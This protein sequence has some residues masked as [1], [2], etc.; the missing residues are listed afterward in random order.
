M[1]SYLSVKDGIYDPSKRFGFK[2]IT[3]E[4][5]TF[6]WG[7]QPIKVKAGQEIELPHHLAVLATGKLVDKIMNDS[8]REEEVK[9][10]TK[11]KDPMWRSPRGLSTGIPEA[12]KPFE[13]QILRELK[14]DDE[15]PQMAVIR[16]QI[17]EELLSDLNAEKAAPVAKMTVK[18]EEFSQIQSKK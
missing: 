10:R 4:D 2:N 3:K 1:S 16:A 9:M 7:N 5:F 11:N 13:T 15:N 8:V 14:I 12:R 18:T 17:R 6:T